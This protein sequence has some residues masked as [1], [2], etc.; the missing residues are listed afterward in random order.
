MVPKHDFASTLEAAQTGAEWALGDLYRG[1]Q[2]SLLRYLVSQDPAEGEDLA[3]DVWLDIGRGIRTFEGDEG[4]FRSWAF[5]IARR[6]LIDLRRKRARR[7]TQPAHPA[8]FLSQP[9][10]TEPLQAVEGGDALSSLALLPADWAEVVLLRVVAG[11]DSNA[12]AA[13]TGKTPGNVRLIQKRALERLAAL[14]P[15][16][17]ESAVT[18]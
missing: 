10:P 5:T 3:S 16:E 9:E 8:H 4:A 12:V 17:D 6:R 18:Q 15:V 1:L 2:P 14:L 7:R 11:L 13:V